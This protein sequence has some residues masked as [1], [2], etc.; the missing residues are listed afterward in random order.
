MELA[1]RGAQP[2]VILVAP[3]AIGET[4]S[5]M[6]PQVDS[7]NLARVLEQVAQ[8]WNVDR[9]A[10]AADRHERRRHVHAC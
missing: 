2:R 6:E 9:D 1:A 8:G 4:W 5:L 7:A 10:S 3:T